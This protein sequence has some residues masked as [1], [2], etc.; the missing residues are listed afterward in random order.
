MIDPQ[1]VAVIL[2]MAGNIVGWVVSFNH[3]NKEQARREGRMTARLDDL[4]ARV[5]RLERRLDEFF[6]QGR[7]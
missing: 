1:W 4:C 3:T 5:D 6:T 7:R 2:V